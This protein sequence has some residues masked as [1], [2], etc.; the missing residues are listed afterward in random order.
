MATTQG[1]GRTGFLK[2][3]RIAWIAVALV[4]I[5][6]IAL[7]PARDPEFSGERVAREDTVIFDLD[8]SIKNPRN[9]NWLTPGVKRLHGAHQAMWE[10][11]F[12]LNYANGEL[13]PWLGLEITSNATHDVWTVSLR[14]GVEWSDGEIFDAD[15]VVFTA[16][17]IIDSDAISARE[18]IRFKGQVAEARKIDSHTVEFRLHQPNPGFHVENFGVLNFS[19]LL[20]MPEHI[21]RGEDVGSFDFYP[22]VGTGPYTFASATSQRAI[23]TRNDNWWGARTGFKDLP[24]PKQLVWIESGGQEN[25]AQLLR[26]NQLDAGQHLALGIFEAI[27]AQ[28]P[29]VVAWHDGFPFSWTDPCPRQLEINTTVAPWDDAGMR[30]AVAHIVDR[31]QIIDIVYEGSTL[32]SKTM[33]VQYGAMQS[34][35]DAVIDAGFE[36]PTGANVDA[37]KRIIE[38]R[39]YSLSEEGIY[40]KD[41]EALTARILANTASAETTGTVDL[42]VEQLQRAGIDARSVPVEDGVFWGEVIPLGEYEMSYS[43]LSC[44]SVNEPWASMVRYTNN[45]MAPIGERAP[46]YNNTGRWNTA[47]TGRYTEIVNRIGEL[48]LGDPSIPGLVADAYESLDAEMPFIPLVQAAKVLSFNKTY[49]RGWPS[50]ND[51]YVHPMHWWNSTHLIIHRLEKADGGT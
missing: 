7:I 51:F 12:V 22:P 39:G 3:G 8:R 16:E 42:L 26:R 34:F 50:A 5:A 15:D 37:A 47:A 1:Q 33:F 19:S 35:I 43:W 21:W 49:W 36:L 25:R 48:P 14:E 11:L 32:P 17:M 31:Q 45:A 27:Q 40:E 9:F 20:V 46:G 2:P 29:R 4:T 24:E 23:W 41:G 38:E 10:P 13:E 28:N 6:L 44:G 30:Q 18:A